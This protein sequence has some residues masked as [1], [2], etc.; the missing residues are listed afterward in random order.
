MT[1]VKLARNTNKLYI[2]KFG[3]NIV[4]DNSFPNI[5]S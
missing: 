5:F 1:D 2:V 4:I 3:F